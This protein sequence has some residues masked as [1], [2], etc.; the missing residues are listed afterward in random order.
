MM[1]SVLQTMDFNEW[2]RLAQQD[3]EAFESI[4]LD[5]I[6]EVIQAAPE[7]Q[8]VKLRCLQWRID[9]ERR[10]SRTPLGACIRLS[11]LMWDRVMGENGLLDHIARLHGVLESPP[12]EKLSSP[13]SA[14][15][16][17]LYPRGCHKPPLP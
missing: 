15:V 6:D 11:H 12:E 13:C 1:K 10:R 16:I 7:E 5:M 3:P 17:P 9:Q 14:K 2:L 8:R 4:R